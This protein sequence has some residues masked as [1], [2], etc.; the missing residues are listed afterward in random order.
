MHNVILYL[1]RKANV[2]IDR[3]VKHPDALLRIQDI[4]DYSG[5]VNELQVE[6]RGTVTEIAAG[7]DASPATARTFWWCITG[8]LG[9]HASME[10]SRRGDNKTPP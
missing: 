9:V 1:C 8:C 7:V 4:P 5:T 10:G 2:P 6:N 3:V